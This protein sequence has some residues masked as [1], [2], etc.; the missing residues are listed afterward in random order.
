MLQ[1]IEDFQSG[2]RF[3]EY[4]LVEKI[5]GGGQ[6]VVWSAIDPEGQVYALK[7]SD[8]TP[9][10]ELSPEDNLYLEQAAR[11][12]DLRHPAILPILD[13]G[14]QGNLRYQAAPFIPGGT[15]F[16]RLSSKPL[17]REEILSYAS[18]MAVALDFLHSKGVIH[19]DLKP[20]NALLDLSGGIYLTDFGLAR[21]LSFETR[22]MHTGRGTP[23]Y[24][25]PEQH[26]HGEITPQSDIFSLGVILYELFT[27]RL[28]WDGERSLGLEM[29]YDPNVV[30]PNPQAE[31]PSLPAGLAG[32][33]ALMTA[34][35]PEDRPANALDALRMLCGV[36]GENADELVAKTLDQTFQPSR[37]ARVLSDY[38]FQYWEPSL[39]VAVMPLTRFV[40]SEKEFRLGHAGEMN[41]THRQFFLQHALLL[42]WRIDWWWE[43]ASLPEKITAGAVLLENADSD[44]SARV[45]TRLRADRSLHPL[46]ELPEWLSDILLRK[47]LESPDPFLRQESLETLSLMAPAG[48]TWKDTVLGGEQDAALGRLASEDSPLRALA[49]RMVAEQR[50]AGAVAAMYRRLDED[51]LEEQL[52]SMLQV[53]GSLPAIVPLQQRMGLQTRLTQE[54]VFSDPRRIWRAFAFAA[55]GGVLGFG[56]LIFATY[57]IMHFLDATR[58]LVALERGLFLGTG[59]AIPLVLARLLVG[60]VRFIPLAWRAV[61]AVSGMT[62]MLWLTFFL[63]GALFLS[64]A[65][66]GWLV[67]AACLLISTGFLA[68]MLLPKW[69]VRFLPAWLA[70]AAAIWASWNLHQSSLPALISPLFYF[71]SGWSDG[72]VLLTAILTSLPPALLGL[73]TDINPVLH[74]K[75]GASQWPR[76]NAI[77]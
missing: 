7:L 33:L 48:R 16:D 27:R 25:P 75:R 38:L 56:G 21:I 69:F 43:Q 53:A 57:R 67:P 18:G 45:L 59:F 13:I 3:R 24:S 15:L 5:G 74:A 55:L 19:R 17:A 61:L 9:Y 37:D 39:G 73:W 10:S 63:N 71:D 51:D 20:A 8:L 49:L 31:D 30:I 68:G 46:P 65:P 52:L 36:F 47:A 2:L 12:R 6:G 29:L 35:K 77:P 4:T 72:K 58:L 50:N 23:P 70:V 22:A 76:S 11:I 40:F 64:N 44:A 62:L 14:Q 66:Q 34:V 26:T 54:R 41:E 1:R 32:V 60:R 42:G 28:P